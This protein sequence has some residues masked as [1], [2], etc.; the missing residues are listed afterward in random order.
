MWAPLIDIPPTSHVMAKRA[1]LKWG[2]ERREGHQ[3]F[4]GSNGAACWM[5]MS[6]TAAAAGDMNDG[7]GSIVVMN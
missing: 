3:L 1:S 5:I 7:D 2:R 4:I 6:I